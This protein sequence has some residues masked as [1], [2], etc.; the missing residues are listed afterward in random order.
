MISN[1]ITEVKWLS[2]GLQQMKISDVA[3]EISSH[4][5]K[6]RIITMAGPSSSNKTTTSL[7]IALAL[8]VLGF[9][10]IVISMD[11]YYRPYSEISKD[12]EGNYDFE[13]LKA[14]NVPALKETFE[15]L[16]QGKTVKQRRNAFD[17]KGGVEIDKTLK[18]EEKQY[19]ILEGILGLHPDFVK[20]IGEANLFR[21]F[22]HPYYLLQ[23]DRHH[24]IRNGEVRLVRRMVRDY[25]FRGYMAEK[26]LS[27]WKK[28]RYSEEINI[29]PFQ[30]ECD[31]IVNTSLV[32]EL[33]VLA[34]YARPLLLEIPEGSE[35]DFL[36]HK[37]LFIIGLF[38]PFG[39]EKKVPGQSF[40]REFIG[41]SEFDL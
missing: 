28:V 4:Y 32:Y 10:T 27:M 3:K 22:V 33:P 38:Y 9:K 13:D 31:A 2:E 5:P 16:L 14:I 36:V 7:R 6:K 12:E 30:N 25:K 37:L 15:A 8:R 1:S 21:I 39:D 23:I 19:I 41:E 29:F 35:N 26:T 34:K 40:L 20:E 18:L 24:Y 17:G 11:D